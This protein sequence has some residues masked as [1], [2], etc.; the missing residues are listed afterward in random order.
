M[1]QEV[2]I[3]NAVSKQQHEHAYLQNWVPDVCGE[4][5]VLL[6]IQGVRC[7]LFLQ[8]K[9]KHLEL[10]EQPSLLASFAHQ[11][12]IYSCRQVADHAL[13]GQADCM[14]ACAMKCS[15][16]WHLVLYKHAC[17]CVTHFERIPTS[18]RRR[19]AQRSQPNSARSAVAAAMRASRRSSMTLCPRTQ[20][21]VVHADGRVLL[22]SPCRQAGALPLCQT[23]LQALTCTADARQQGKRVPL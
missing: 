5:C 10:G 12:H 18:M 20:S 9:G 2:S 23:G 22:V 15:I 1:Q 14:Y 13:P 19:S 6:I 11:L 16:L 17:I 21:W 8:P 7:L 4:L 3:S